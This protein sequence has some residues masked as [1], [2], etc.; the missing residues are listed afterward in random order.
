M[1][2]AVLHLNK[3]SGNDAAM[4]AHIERTIEPKNADK[5][6]THLNRE[7]IPFPD[8][9]TS[10]T[11]AIRHRIETAG[12]TRKIGHNQVRAIR[13]MLS[14]THDD[15]KRIEEAGKLNDWR[16]DNV[17]WLKQTFGGD[18]LVSAVLHLDEKT[19]HIHATVV[20]VVLGERRKAKTGKSAEGKK[21]Y[22]K[23]NPN[24][25]RLCADDVMARDKLKCY[26]DS[27]A[28]AM[29][30]YG[31]Q[32]GI[33]GSEARHVTTP[34]Y[35]RELYLQNKNLKE[36][37][38]ILQEQETEAR[39]ELSRIK[40]A[41]KTEKLKSSAVDV[42]TSAI[43][44]I[45]SVLGASK[46]KRQQQEI[47]EQKSENASLKTEIKT[48]KQQIQM[49]EGEHAKVTDKLRQELEKIY[50]LFPKIKELLCIENLCRHLGFSESMT[51]EILKMKPVGFRGKLYSAEYRRHFETE[52]SVAEIKPSTSE[53]DKLRLTI[54]GVGDVGWFRQKNRE[55]LQKMG[56][57]VGQESG[58]GKGIKL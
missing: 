46:V 25:A 12:I 2:F 38:E 33:E 16:Y 13:V 6:R 11:D 42:A 24:A 27:Y 4:T 48:L 55:F 8:G 41:I 37:I 14:G 52:H 9:I 18:N 23:K 50:A 1:G 20:P 29:A 26:Q 53:P 43:E 30:K 51:G 58:R 39:Q 57:N 22:K 56:I 49:N 35:Y 3:A 15:M 32:R 28:L 17:N 40:G 44:G 7:L 5:S 45:G 31:L 36:G 54:D 34:Q 21:K 10:R 47:E 19:P